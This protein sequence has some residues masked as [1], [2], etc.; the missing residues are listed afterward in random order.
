MLNSEKIILSN[1]IK[2]LYRLSHLYR[3]DA[4]L[5]NEVSDYM[6]FMITINEISSLNISMVNSTLADWMDVDKDEITT[7]G[8]PLIKSVSD[9]NYLN[10]AIKSIRCFEKANNKDNLCTYFQKLILSGRMNYLLSHKI[11]L[12]NKSYINFGYQLNLFD[13]LNFSVNDALDEFTDPNNY[14][15]KYL[16]LTN[17]EKEIL[18]YLSIG[19]TN[20]EI[21]ELINTSINT[22]RTQRNSLNYKLGIKNFRDI[23]KASKV[24]E[25]FLNYDNLSKFPPTS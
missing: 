2:Q 4:N 9:I 20:K 16:T 24:F 25:L 1:S 12:D 19:M 3:R 15:E 18:K 11:F 7:K 21:A 17:R 22:V 10:H 8:V 6:P 23:L 5:F 14:F 13:K